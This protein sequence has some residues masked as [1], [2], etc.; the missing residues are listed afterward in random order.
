MSKREIEISELKDLFKKDCPFIDVRA[1]IEY[2]QG[3][4]P[5]ALNLPI[6]NDQ[7]R[8]QVGTI[9]KEQGQKAA[10]D[11]GHQLVSGPHKENRVKAW[12]E[13]LHKNPDAILYCFRGGLRSQITRDWISNQGIER[14]LL[15]G[16]YKAARKFL[17]DEID[18][19]S[20]QKSFLV[21]T[22]PTGSGKTTL[23][24]EAQRFSSTIDLEK[25]ANHRGSAFGGFETPQPSQANFEN[26]MAVSLLRT[27][28]K[29][30]PEIP[31]LVEDESRLI[32]HLSLPEKFFQKM[33][34]SEVIWIEEN[35]ESRVVHVFNDYIKE[36]HE[37]GRLAETLIRY[38]K[39]VLNISKKLG[40][41][42]ARELLEIIDSA[43]IK[44]IQSGDPKGHLEWIEKLLVF[45]YDPAYLSSLERRQVKCRFR[46]S[47]N[48]CLEYLFAQTR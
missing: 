34:A 35:L 4:L 16:G 18:R 26:N 46:G 17:I 43:E 23:L 10:I 36:P 14:P 25:L 47:R 20:E 15:K 6:L 33:R 38:K 5:G 11:L 21:V 32:G 8:A 37:S 22:G 9:Y 42:R 24:G 39:A 28:H 48:D 30:K 27:D 31:L 1:P 29:Q 2:A 7:E 45:Y 12:I 13:F 3:H 44:R 19:V 41:A 40:G